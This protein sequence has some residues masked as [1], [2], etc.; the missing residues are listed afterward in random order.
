MLIQTV[1][2]PAIQWH[3]TLFFQGLAAVLLP[4]ACGAQAP[5]SFQLALTL[6]LEARFATADN[7]GHVYVLTN[8]H[9]L[10]KYAPDGRLLAR[11]TNNRLGP[12]HSVDVSNPLKVFVW[13]ADFRAVV[14]LD[15]SLTPLGELSL[16]DA[17]YPDA[18]IVAAAADGN[19][20]LY[21]DTAFLLRKISPEGLPIRESQ[22]LNQLLPGRVQIACLRDDG[23][24]VLAAD[25]TRGVLFFDAYGQFYN[26]LGGSGVRDF[27]LADDEIVYCRDSFLVRQP[28]A[29][30]AL[31]R[32]LPLP[33][34]ARAP[35]SRLWLGAGRLL[36]LNDKRL[37]V[38]KF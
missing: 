10:E 6:P 24:R 12:A 31:P 14:F 4:L 1:F 30:R 32:L 17:G 18:R 7:L 38:F 37:F 19:L 25:T 9:T 8:F 28:V 23:S 36:A 34:E 5:D 33:P 21:D 2:Q 29:G 15:R 11:Y 13:F 26:L 3:K 35:G 22:P 27:Q 16:I 20:W